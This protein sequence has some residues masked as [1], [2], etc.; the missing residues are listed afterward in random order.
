M[1]QVDEPVAEVV[2]DPASR[3]DRAPVILVV[4]EPPLRMVE[5]RGV[6]NCVGDDQRVV[7]HEQADV[8][9]VMAGQLDDRNARNDLL[10][11]RHRLET[12]LETEHAAA[13]VRTVGSTMRGGERILVEE[14]TGPREGGTAVVLCV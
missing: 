3:L 10:P 7:A 5:L 11:A 6:R 2:A 8:T 14:V 4:P 9:V 13:D 1:A 12:I